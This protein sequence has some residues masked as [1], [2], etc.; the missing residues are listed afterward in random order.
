MG[1]QTCNASNGNTS[2]GTYMPPTFYIL[3]RSED[4]TVLFHTSVVNWAY[5]DVFY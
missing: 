5:F 1:R 3:S 2:N 4:L